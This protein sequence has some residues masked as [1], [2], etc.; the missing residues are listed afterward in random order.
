MIAGA[1]ALMFALPNLAVA[2]PLSD[3]DRSFRSAYTDASARKLAALR[4]Q[5]PVLVNR[6]GQIALYRPNVIM[7]EIFS[8]DMRLYL[9]ARSVAHAPVAVVARLTPIKFSQLDTATLEWFS[10]FEV[11]LSKAEST[12]SQRPGLPSEARDAQQEFLA[13]IRRYVQRIRQTSVGRIRGRRT[14]RYPSEFTIGSRFEIG[15]IPKSN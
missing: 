8:M 9:D 10:N 11:S 5:V 15:S 13:T 3:L 6:F 14:A 12:I 7:P 4:S 2:D 1:A